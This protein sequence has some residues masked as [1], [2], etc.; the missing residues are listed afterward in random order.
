MCAMIEMSWSMPLPESSRQP[1]YVERLLVHALRQWVADRSRWS[2]V[3]LE[4]N[5]ICGPHAATQICEAL[6]SA[7]ETLGRHARRRVR[8]HRPVCCRIS[9]DETCLLNLIAARQNGADGHAHALMRWMVKS[10]F[11]AE[12]ERDLDIVAGVLLEAGYTL[13]VR[14]RTANAETIT[15][16]PQLRSVRE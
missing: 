9:H 4:F 2:G 13:E 5:R 3:V 7:F 16:T 6:D 10:A 15:M 14:T 11:A 1:T 8:L 12:L